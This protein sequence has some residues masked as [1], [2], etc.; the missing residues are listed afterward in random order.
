MS[1]DITANQ[2]DPRRCDNCGAPLA[3]R[4]SPCLACHSVALDA[5]GADAVKLPPRR[6]WQPSPGTLVYPYD[7]IDEAELVA[8]AKRRSRGRIALAVS[9]LAVSSAVYLACIHG[10]ELRLGVP[11][12]STGLVSAQNGKAPAAA[13][14][15]SGAAGKQLLPSGVAQQQQQTADV[16]QRVASVPSSPATPVSPPAASTPEQRQ[17]V[18]TTPDAARVT[19]TQPTDTNDK[20]RVDTRP[21]GS[22]QQPP[23]EI[24]QQP[25][26]VRSSPVTAPAA[27]PPEQHRI[28]STA[29]NAARV[30]VAP[31]VDA[32]DKLR[33]A[34]S[35][36]AVEQHLAS[37]RPSPVTPPTASPLE[38]PRVASTTPDAARATTD[39][40]LSAQNKLRADAPP[41]ASAQQQPATVDQRL[42]SVRPAAPTPPAASPPEQHRIASTT[43]DTARATVNQPI[44]AQN[45]PRTDARPSASAQQQPAIVTQRLASVRPAAPTPPAASPPEQHRIASTT[46]DTARATVNQPIGAQNNP[47]A[48][49]RPSASAQQQPAI[50]TQRLASVRPAAPTPPAASPSGQR[51][52]A[53]TTP[54]ASR[55]IAP[56]PISAE[57]QRRADAARYLKAA[58]VSLKANNLSV[59]KSR[60]AAAL[61][62][63]PDNR[64]ALRLRSTVHTLEQQRD[65]LLSLARGCRSID[66][67]DCT[68]RNAGIALQID[69][70]SKD[71]RR[72][73]TR[74]ERESALQIV[75]SA[76]DVTQPMPQVRYLHH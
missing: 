60:I 11:L 27:L 43:P 4:F 42:A 57:D 2:Q 12:A 70:S 21:S 40:P 29:P 44:G 37:V 68:S 26:P 19:A 71:A 75:S 61:A 46:P 34:A 49:A 58:R 67:L 56:Q 47:R 25:A 65:A 59:A 53:S 17:A 1:T 13:A 23:A 8:K 22:S 30:T 64:D 50:V 28:A 7:S 14:G 69:S 66:H 73:A 9:V 51:L 76:D 32:E 54:D 63:Q 20:L 39:H 48:D 36:T 5:F 10:D 74:A 33:T 6:I 18:T 52:I 35:P 3:G 55:A 16:A 31:P 41:S 62:V 38:Q 15:D 24:A 72:L 45:N